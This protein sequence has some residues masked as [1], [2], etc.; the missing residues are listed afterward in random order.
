M[1][2]VEGVC[3]EDAAYRAEHCSN[4]GVYTEPRMSEYL[5]ASLPIPGLVKLRCVT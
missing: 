5:F 1:L 2:E 4:V 3:L